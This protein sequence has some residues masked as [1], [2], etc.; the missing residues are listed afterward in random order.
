MGHWKWLEDREVTA[1]LGN[2]VTSL[3]AL[4][5]LWV[6]LQHAE[7]LECIVLMSDELE[8]VWKEVVVA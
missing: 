7:Y 3:H 4:I 6:I 1:K 2:L 5:L 8:R